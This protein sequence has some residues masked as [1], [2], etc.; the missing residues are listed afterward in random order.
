MKG[1]QEYARDFTPSMTREK[2]SRLMWHIYAKTLS[3]PADR[4]VT[5]SPVKITPEIPSKDT[6][7]EQMLYKSIGMM[8]ESAH[9]YSLTGTK[10]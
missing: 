7:Q 8:P 6:N 10:C 5:A 4:S 2:E 3:R 9:R 1:E